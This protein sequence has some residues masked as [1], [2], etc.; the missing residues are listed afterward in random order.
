[1]NKND[2]LYQNKKPYKSISYFL[3]GGVGIGKT[4]TFMCI[5]KTCYNIILSKL[6]RVKANYCDPLWDTFPSVTK[7]IFV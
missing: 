6:Q 3:I 5:Y 7:G 2:F 4:F 1:M